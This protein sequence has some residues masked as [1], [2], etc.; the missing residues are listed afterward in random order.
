MPAERTYVV[1]VIN[2]SDQF[3]Q[4]DMERKGVNGK[5]EAVPFFVL[6]RSEA[7]TM[8]EAAAKMFVARLRSLGV[9]N[10]WIED[11]KDG[12]R[13]DSASESSQSG[14]DTR[15]PVAATIDDVNWYVVKPICRPDGRKWFLKIVVPGLPDPYV[16]YGDDPLAALT[17]AEDLGYLR[18]A[19][20]YERPQPQQAPV[21]NSSV[22]R[23]RPGDLI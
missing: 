2:G 5:F 19:E 23:R 7:T 22:V 10:A 11:C 20:R 1:A 6:N 12:R 13:I 15:T 14:E 4:R 9:T 18:F 3:Y 21:R 8:S 17:R 16:T